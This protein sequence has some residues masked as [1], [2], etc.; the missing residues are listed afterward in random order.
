MSDVPTPES[1]ASSPATSERQ[2]LDLA[3]V[4]TILGCSR[5]TACRAAREGRLPVLRIGRRLVVPRRVLDQWLTSAAEPL[6][7]PERKHPQRGVYH[8]VEDG[9][10]GGAVPSSHQDAS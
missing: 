8:N 6:I 7:Q 1:A 10:S 5:G 2:T 3:E 4:V 9:M